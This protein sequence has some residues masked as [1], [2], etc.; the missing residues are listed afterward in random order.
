MTARQDRSLSGE[1]TRIPSVQYL[2]GPIA[3]SIGSLCFLLLG[4]LLWS[5]G[6]TDVAIGAIV[7]AWLVTL[8]GLSLY[9]WDRL[10]DAI[11]ARDR[12]P[13]E[14]A[15]D[16]AL[17]APS[18]SVEHK[19]ELGAGF[20]QVLT[21]VVTIA[22]TIGVFKLFG[23]DGGAILLTGLIAAGNLGALVLAMR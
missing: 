2:E 3:H 13:T 1:V 11:E 5:V 12:A 16:R 19:A 18:L 17:S 22:L 15:P 6:V 23:V 7:V 4:G 14:D 21:L 8:N 20:L 10:R 9:G